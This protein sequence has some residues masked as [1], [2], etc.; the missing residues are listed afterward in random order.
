MAIKT[1]V[2]AG[3]GGVR[4]VDG[5]LDRYL[6]EL[7]L[8]D[9]LAVLD[10]RR[11]HTAEQVID[12]CIPPPWYERAMARYERL[13]ID[14]ADAQ[15]VLAQWLPRAAQMNTRWKARMIRRFLLIVPVEGRFTEAGLADVAALARGMSAERECRRLFARVWAFSPVRQP[16]AAPAASQGGS[17]RAMTS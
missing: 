11:G 16:A 7:I 3:S 6:L 14:G 2:R 15:D 13:S 12:R 1:L 10:H 9:S 8:L 4:L 17:S 5:R